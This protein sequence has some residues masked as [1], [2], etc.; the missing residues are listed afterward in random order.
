MRALRNRVGNMDVLVALGTSAAYFFSL[1]LWL[2]GAGGHLYFESA[3]V[4]ITLVL[5]GKWMEGRAKQSASASVR[6]LLSLRPEQVTR[7]QNGEESVVPVAQIRTG[8]RV[9][10]RPGE[11]VPV[12]VGCPE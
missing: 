6:E 11:R 8:D 4:V 1:A 3:A 2:G 5:F 9:R 10:I 12:D 7:L